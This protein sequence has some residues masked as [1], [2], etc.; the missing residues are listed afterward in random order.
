MRHVLHAL[1]A[2]VQFINVR[3]RQAFDVSALPRLVIPK[4]Q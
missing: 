1:D 2:S 4:I 3:L